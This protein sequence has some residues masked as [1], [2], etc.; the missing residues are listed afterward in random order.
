MIMDPLDN[1]RKFI[2]IRKNIYIH[3]YLY[4]FSK[5]TQIAWRPAIGPL[6]IRMCL[7]SGG[8]RKGDENKTLG[9]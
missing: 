4:R 5:D 7:V 1:M 6:G 3:K 8:V 9:E 2:F